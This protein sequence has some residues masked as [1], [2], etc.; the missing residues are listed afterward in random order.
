MNYLLEYSNYPW[1][2]FIEN[3]IIHFIVSMDKAASIT[4]PQLLFLEEAHYIFEKWNFTNRLLG[5]DIDSFALGIMHAYEGCDL[6]IVESRGFTKGAE[7]S[8]Q[9][10][11]TVDLPKCSDSV[12]PPIQFGYQ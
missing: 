5:L 4:R 3:N 10:I 2:S 9:D 7:P 8:R 11:G 6:P 12:M 1:L